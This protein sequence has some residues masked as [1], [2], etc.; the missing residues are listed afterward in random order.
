MS[1]KPLGSAEASTRWCRILISGAL[2]GFGALVISPS[3]KADETLVPEPIGYLENESVCGF[4][5]ERL[6]GLLWSL[7]AGPAN[8]ARVQDLRGIE[9]VSFDTIDGRRLGGY[10]LNSG[11]LAHRYIL[12]GLGNA[13]LADQVIGEFQFLQDAGFDVYAYDHRGY[14]LSEG[15]S[16][17]AALRADFVALIDHLNHEDYKQGFVYGMSFGGVMAMNALGAGAEVDAA[18]IDSPPSRVSAYG[19]PRSFDPVENLPERAGNLGFIFGQD[20]RVVPPAQWREL[21][22]AARQRGA[23]VIERA[24]FGH[25]LQDRWPRAREA[26]RDIIRGFFRMHFSQ[27][28]SP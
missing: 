21:A 11:G 25:P 3:T 19:C 5:K 15:K 22:D 10:K 16:R 8:A 12:I 27:D 6:L 17:F 9:A 4:F 14:G 26:R 23:A 28:A 18:L 24:D 20:D 7:L 2:V 1:R 13:M